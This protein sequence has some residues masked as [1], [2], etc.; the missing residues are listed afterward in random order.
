VE[1]TGCWL[2]PGLGM[3][4]AWCVV[5]CSQRR[6][7]L[8]GRW[9]VE[10]TRCEGA[11][12]VCGTV[13]SH[14][15]QGAVHLFGTHGGEQVDLRRR[16]RPELEATLGEREWSR[17]CNHVRHLAGFLSG[18]ELRVN[19][20]VVGCC[21]GGRPWSRGGRR[22]WRRRGEVNNGQWVVM[23]GSKASGS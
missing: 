20:P 13:P 23:G 11:Q 9:T 1:V 6:S 7:A 17:E 15:G 2:V 19:G 3:A 5:Y 18:P 8:L 21:G 12:E 16:L 14:L 22:R 10:Q 4:A